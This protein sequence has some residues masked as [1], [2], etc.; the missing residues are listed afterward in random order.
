MLG[1]D[2]RVDLKEVIAPGD[3][4][5]LATLLSVLPEG[6]TAVAGHVM[7]APVASLTDSSQEPVVVSVL[8]FDEP[9]YPHYGGHLWTRPPN[10]ALEAGAVLS[11]SLAQKL[12]LNVGDSIIIFEHIVSVAA[13]VPDSLLSAEDAHGQ[14]RVIALRS[15]ILKSGGDATQLSGS[16]TQFFFALHSARDLQ[17]TIDMTQ[18]LVDLVGREEVTGLSDIAPLVTS[19]LERLSAVFFWASLIVLF[20]CAFGIAFGLEDYARSHSLETAILRSYGASSSQVALIMAIRLILVG[21][22]TGVLTCATAFL[23]RRPLSNLFGFFSRDMVDLALPQVISW[24]LIILGPVLIFVYG[25]Y[26][27]KITLDLKP[28]GVLRQKTVGF[29][30]L[31]RPEQSI[32]SALTVILVTLS[33]TP[34]LQKLLLGAH[35]ASLAP[36]LYVLA[37]CFVLFLAIYSGMSRPVQN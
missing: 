23:L 11:A 26:A 19:G 9:G 12:G 1:A 17:D 21:L 10:E 24:P 25:L 28:F 6:T 13:L 35:A 36:A 20:I 22:V 31:G 7:M 32:W 29:P 33:V 4:Q 14:G 16:L 37:F 30:L 18:S 34:F 3:T 8:V 15:V 5:R 27:F 2:V